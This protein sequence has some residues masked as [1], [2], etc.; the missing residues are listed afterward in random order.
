MNLIL[1][2]PGRAGGAVGLA[3]TRAGH[4]IVGVLSRTGNSSYGP[5]LDWDRTLP[6]ADLLLVAV[7]DDAIASVAGRLAGKCR[8]VGVAAHLSGF[9]AVTALERLRGDGVAVGGFHPLQT[10][11]DPPRGAA[12]LG[13]AH[14][15]IGGDPGAVAVLEELGL[16]LGM[17]PFPLPDTARPAYHAA[18]AAAANFVITALGTA[19]ELFRWAGIDP[20]VARPLVEQ[21]VANVYASGA[22]QS[23]TGPIAR[24]DHETVIGHLAAAGAV[25]ERLGRRYRLLAEAT[26]ILAGRD[27]EVARWR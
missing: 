27:E 2:G 17:H 11:P 26:A 4:V 6:A 16:S 10:L 20:V 7:R 5:S 14:V 12:A 23:L 9:V 25:S 8:R 21:A 18:A 22:E 24:G 1:V 13:G 3:A 15:G 19:G